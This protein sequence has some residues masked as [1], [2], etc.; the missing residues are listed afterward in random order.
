MKLWIIPLAAILITGVASVTGQE[1]SNS[2]KV[3]NESSVINSSA[4][5]ELILDSQIQ[6]KT[7]LFTLDVD[8]RL[9]IVNVTSPNETESQVIS[10]RSIGAAALNSTAKAMKIVLASISMQEGQEENAST[11]AT[12]MYLLNDTLYMKVD[13]NWTRITLVGLSLESLWEQENEIERQREELNNSNITFLGYENVNGIDCY[14]IQVIPDMKAYAALKENQMGSS[15]SS[16]IASLNLSAL[17][18]N[19]SI[20]EISWISRETLLPAK[21]EISMNMTLTPVTL[22]LPEKKAGRL[23]MRIDTLETIAFSGFNRS[24][25][26]ALPEEAKGARA[27]PALLSTQT[28]SSSMNA[29]SANLTINSTPMAR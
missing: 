4:L 6:P 15:L 16:T 28:N 1:G 23:E 3:V 2:S 11:M 21:T 17:F 14:K 24:I 7:Y 18:N 13:G 10:T 12:D 8:Q 22:G 5:K 29:T 26:I 19:A 25:D 9:E 20:S 27:F